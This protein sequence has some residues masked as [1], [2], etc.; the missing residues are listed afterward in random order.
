MEKEERKRRKEA[1]KHV[2]KN[3]VAGIRAQG[4]T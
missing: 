4:W 3:G 1:S 2:D